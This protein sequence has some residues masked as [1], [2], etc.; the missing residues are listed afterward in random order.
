MLF[1]ETNYT[2]TLNKYFRMYIKDLPLIATDL[3]SN[4]CHELTSQHS[5]FTEQNNYQ[6]D[7]RD[8]TYNEEFPVLVGVVPAYYARTKFCLISCLQNISIE[9]NIQEKS[10]FL[11]NMQ[12]SDTK[13]RGVYMRCFKSAEFSKD[14]RYIINSQRRNQLSSDACGVVRS[15]LQL[16]S[17]K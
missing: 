6:I 11:S 17:P 3:K 9:N 7:V 8:I 1:K 16:F 10:Q 4:Q 14:T 5:S 12:K 13:I 15:L 2:L